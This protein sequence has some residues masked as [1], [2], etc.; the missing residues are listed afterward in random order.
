V[1]LIAKFDRSRPPFR[2]KSDNLPRDEQ[3]GVLFLRSPSSTRHSR[4]YYSRLDQALLLWAIAIAIIFFTAQFHAFDWHHQARAWSAVSLAALV[5][6]SLRAWPWAVALQ[7][8]WLLVWWGGIML[9]GLGLTDY[10]IYHSVIPILLNLCPLWLGLSALGYGVTALAMGSQALLGITA[11]HGLAI[12]L[13]HLWPAGLFCITG[14]TM[15][16][17]L[18]LLA[19]LEWDHC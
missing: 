13:L 19:Q 12:G 3:E 15:A 10:G 5:L 1:G 9:L 4:L 18:I 17:S 6:S 8:R 16:G 11:V 2:L 14:L 7:R